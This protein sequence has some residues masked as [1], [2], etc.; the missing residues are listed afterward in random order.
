[1]ILVVHGI[2]ERVVLVA[3]FEDGGRK[4]Y[5]LVETESLCKA[6]RRDIAHDNLKGDYLHLLHHRFAGRKLLD[7]MRG[8]AVLFEKLH[9]VIRHAVVDLALAE[10]RALFQSVERGRIVLVINDVKLRIVGRIN[11]FAL[12]S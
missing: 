7:K 1:M 9:K 10:D 3:V 5:S 4:L 11:L 2:A 8:N 6:S 12:P